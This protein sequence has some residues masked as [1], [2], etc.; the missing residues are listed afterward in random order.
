MEG[1]YSKRK[2]LRE[3]RELGKYNEISKIF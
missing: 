3:I 1:I 2:H